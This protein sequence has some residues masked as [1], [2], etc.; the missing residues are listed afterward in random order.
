MY[1]ENPFHSFQHASHVTASVKKL[2]TRI[3]KVGEGNGLAAVSS[4][5]QRVDNDALLVDLA[6]HGYGITSDPLTQFAVV[7]SAV[8]HDVD[9]PGVPNVQL[10]KEKTRNAEYYKK[11]EAAFS[12]ASPT[13][14]ENQDDRKAT[15][16]IEHLIQASDVSHTM[17]HWH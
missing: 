10:V 8:I 13:C 4:E 5:I 1:R 11:W 17:Q 14:A 3:V 15:I 7:F 6:R 2:L 12:N 9:H 16:V